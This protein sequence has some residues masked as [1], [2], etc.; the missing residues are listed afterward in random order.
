MHYRVQFLLFVE[1]IVIKIPTVYVDGLL[2][3]GCQNFP[4]LGVTTTN[5]PQYEMLNW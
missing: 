4:P 2:Y 1:L 5:V 3:T